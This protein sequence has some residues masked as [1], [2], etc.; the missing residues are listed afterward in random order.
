MRILAKI[1][2]VASLAVSLVIGLTNMAMAT[3]DTDNQTVTVTL[4]EISELAASG[5]PGTLTFATPAAGFLPA[6]QSDSSTTMAWTSNVAAAQTRKITGSLDVLFSGVDLYGTLAAPGAAGGTSAG[7]LKF[8]AAATAYDF[9]TAIGN[10]NSVGNTITFRAS[11]AAMAAP[12]GPTA[13]TVTWT[14][15]EDG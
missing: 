12:F 7:E 13:Q 15:T 14:L 11:L 2:A 5:N 8:T 6:D 1:L 9:V 4:S 10:S 3:T